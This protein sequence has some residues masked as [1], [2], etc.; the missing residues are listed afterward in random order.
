MFLAK[1]FVAALLTCFRYTI[2]STSSEQ[3]C[4]TI[5]PTYDI[6]F[7]K[8]PQNI[9]FQTLHTPD[10]IFSNI[11]GCQIAENI[12]KI[13]YGVRTNLY[14]Y[15]ASGQMSKKFAVHN[16]KL[17][18]RNVYINVGG[19]AYVSSMLGSSEYDMNA[20]AEAVARGE[21]KEETVFMTDYMTYLIVSLC[22]SREGKV[23]NSIFTTKPIMSAED[24]LN[25]RN[26]LIEA[27]AM[28]LLEKS[29]CSAIHF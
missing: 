5:P 28:T 22:N 8:L 26:S 4:G 17:S 20:I 3:G 24:I 13:P 6:D 12:T 25:I 23:T 10:E 7:T 1:V 27:N 18:R 21:L 16:V 29:N 2:V 19:P 9:W 14:N 11:V 15:Y